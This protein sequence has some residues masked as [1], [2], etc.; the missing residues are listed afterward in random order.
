MPG[1]IDLTKTVSAVRSASALTEKTFLEIAEALEASIGILSNLAASFETA[2]TE[3][4]NEKLRLALNALGGAAARVAELGS[5]HA[6]ASVR[7]GDMQCVAEAIAGRILKMNRSV[8]SIDSLAINSKIAAAAI[9]GSKID[10]SAFADE[11]E[12]TLKMTRSSLASFAAELQTVRTY[13]EAAYTGQV[14]FEQGQNE[15]TRSIPQRLNATVSSMP[16]KHKRSAQALSAVGQRS[17][18][19]RQQV[20]NAILALQAGDMTRQRLEHAEYAL[21]LIMEPPET[22]EHAALTEDEQWVFT[23]TACRVQSAQLAATAAEFQRNIGQ[24]TAS[25]KSMAGEARVLRGLAGS[26]YGSAEH[27]GGSFIGDLEAHVG[28]A[29]SLFEDY[30]TAR[31]EAARAMTSVA[32][33]T[34]G[35]CSHLRT[36]QSLE[37]DIRIMGLNT[38][39]QCALVGPEGRALGLI[40]QELRAYGHEFA[41]EASALIG[42]VDKLTQITCLFTSTEPDAATLVATVR[43]TMN[44]SLSSLRQVGQILDDTLS[45]LERDSDRVVL[46][47]EGTA[48][49]LV[50]H[51]GIGEALRQAEGDLKAIAPPDALP[52]YDLAPRARQMLDMMEVVYTMATERIIHNRV[53][54]RSSGGTSAAAGAKPELED[55]LF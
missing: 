2:L 13:V 49:N 4:R 5:S 43:E 33:A 23:I 12:R 21:N 54:G 45:A 39:L 18:R 35:L 37:D 8:G 48:E 38:T 44:D 6:A 19:I 17:E 53:L 24:I 52:A 31:G 20:R 32:D 29:L 25:L 3:L 42:E 14:T 27:A 47:L 15:A 10:F 50:S 36:V 1:C 7:F 34:D 16:S 51:D 40:A 26:T 22:G 28:A 46:L 30:G 11:I 9:R 41:K 55:M